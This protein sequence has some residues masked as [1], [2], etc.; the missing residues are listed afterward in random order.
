MLGSG[1]ALPGRQL[2]PRRLPDQHR[3]RRAGGRPR[4][5][6][7]GPTRCSSCRRSSASHGGRE[8]IGVND[9]VLTSGMLGRMAM[10]EWRGR[11]PVA[12]RAR[13]A[14]GRSW[15]PRPGR[16]RTTCRRAGRCWPGVWTRSCSP[17][18]RRTRC[19]PGRWCSAGR[20]T[21]SS[22]TAPR[23]CRCEVIVDGHVAGRL[24]SAGAVSGEHGRRRRAARPALGDVVLRPLPEHR[25]RT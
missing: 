3:R 21:W 18:S 19:T 16:R 11:R 7:R 17:S 24:D 25:S 10:L 5:A 6:L 15:P 1:V 4:A 14:T 20:T 8:L 22:P 2:R 9:I 13:A 12:G 23:T